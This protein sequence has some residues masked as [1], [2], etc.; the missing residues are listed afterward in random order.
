MSQEKP[1]AANFEQK[2]ITKYVFKEFHEVDFEIE[3]FPELF[4]RLVELSNL[5]ESHFDDAVKMEKIVEALWGDIKK[6]KMNFTLSELKLACLFHDI[7]KSGPVEANKRQRKIIINQIFNTEYFNPQKPEFK[8]KNIKNLTIGEALEL[9]NFSN[10]E[11]IKQY[12]KTLTLHIFYKDKKQ[13]IEEKLDLNKH[14]LIDLWREHDYWTYQLL[15]KYG[16]QKIPKDLIIITSSH[17]T[18]EGYDPAMIDGNMPNEAITLELLDKYLIVTL[19]DKYQAWIDRAG[20]NHDE[21]IKIIEKT[22]EQSHR[23]GII[24]HDKKIY[25]QF[26]KYLQILDKHPEIYNLTKS[27]Q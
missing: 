9:E 20:K 19:V 16:D 17:H 21:A 24:N 4:E 2:K 22:I 14:R 13:I 8:N 23:E 7:G 26:M 10:K 1:L 18:L 3:K 15:K 12:L 6:E 5:P 25:N 11:E 27:K